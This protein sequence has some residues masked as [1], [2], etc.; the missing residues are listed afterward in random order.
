VPIATSIRAT[1]TGGNV[2][3]T[4]TPDALANPDAVPGEVTTLVID[5]QTVSVVVLEVGAEQVEVDTDL[6]AAELEG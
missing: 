6:H 3:H 4:V 1:W 2:R 5:D